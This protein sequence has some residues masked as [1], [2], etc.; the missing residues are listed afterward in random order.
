MSYETSPDLVAGV[1]V[2]PGPFR[3]EL[4]PSVVKSAARTIQILEFF[5]HVRR[6]V[7]ISEIASALNYPQSS[8]SALLR[9]MVTMGYLQHD[10]ETRTYRLTRRTGLLGSWVDP[11]L[12]KQGSLVT[13]AQG[14]ARHTGEYVV[15]ARMNE[16]SVQV[17]YSAEG[18]DGRAPAP[19]ALHSVARSAQGMALLAMMDDRQVRRILTRIN[20]ER[21]PGESAI[22]TADWMERM[23]EGRRRRAFSGAGSA[24]GLHA[25]AAQVRHQSAGDMLVIAIEGPEARL[26]PQAE[27]LLPMMSQ[28]IAQCCK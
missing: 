17:I 27:R 10:R 7:S 25:V 13:L 4:P 3:S 16:L 15:L 9:S 21:R 26:S 19:G 5:D 8:T 22:D 2:S 11:S 28:A 23:S 18:T 12:V 14:L 24:P 20:A 6:D 1:P